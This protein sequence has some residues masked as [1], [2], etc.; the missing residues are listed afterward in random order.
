MENRCSDNRTTVYC[1]YHLCHSLDDVFVRTSEE[2][3]SFYP[4]RTNSN[5]LIICLYEIPEAII[6]LSSNENKIKI[7][8]IL[9]N[10]TKTISI[11][12]FNMS[13]RQDYMS[14]PWNLYDISK[15]KN[16]SRCHAVFSLQ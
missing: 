3:H 13:I 14:S 4:N 16:N 1:H 2:K 15:E 11:D 8:T 6:H 5:L 7:N 12:R 10:K 9:L